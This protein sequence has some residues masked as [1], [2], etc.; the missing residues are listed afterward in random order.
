MWQ[1]DTMFGLPVTN[2]R[3]KTQ[4]KLMAFIFEQLDHIRLGYNTFSDEA[5]DL[6][7]RSSE[8]ILRRVRNLCVSALL[9]TAR[10]RKQ[11]V[12][13]EQVNKVLK[14]LQR[15]SLKIH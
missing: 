11:V 3:T 13:M 8:G 4:T 7:V 12:G 15:L 6:I 14:N 9:E 10:D 1:L 2:S 5:L